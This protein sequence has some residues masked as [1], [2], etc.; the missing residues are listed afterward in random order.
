MLITKNGHIELYRYG[1]HYVHPS[2]SMLLGL[3]RWRLWFSNKPQFHLK[4]G[5]NNWNTRQTLQH[6]FRWYLEG[7]MEPWLI[8]ISWLHD[9]RVLFR[10]I[11]HWIIF[12]WTA[13][14]WTI[15]G[16]TFGMRRKDLKFN[17]CSTCTFTEE[18][19]G[20]GISTKRANVLLNPSEYKIMSSTQYNYRW[21]K[22][23][24]L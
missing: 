23:Y 17:T 15:T 1:H 16:F 6:L 12:F 4:I 19:D 11:I 7:P 24:R 20:V 18:S 8:P 9:G 22:N 2:L 13:E 5:S 10:C 21:N 3:N 14:V